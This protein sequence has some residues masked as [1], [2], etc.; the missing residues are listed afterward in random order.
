MSRGT[1]EELSKLGNNHRAMSEET[2]PQ[3]EECSKCEAPLDTT[4]FPKW[5]K[6]C[7]AKYK[8]EYEAT[9]KEMS[10][11]RGYAA[12]FSAGSAAMQAG[13]AARV[14]AVGNGKFSGLRFAEWIKAFRLVSK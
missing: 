4:G 7:R 1:N 12:G 10:E 5:C 8:R 9:K 3:T 11:T 2:K 14:A 13:I 6:A